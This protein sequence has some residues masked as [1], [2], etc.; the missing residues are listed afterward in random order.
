MLS[1]VELRRLRALAADGDRDAL[2]AAR[3]WALA[4]AADPQSGARRYHRRAAERAGRRALAR[5]GATA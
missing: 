2:A 5:S 3:E 4:R 1:R